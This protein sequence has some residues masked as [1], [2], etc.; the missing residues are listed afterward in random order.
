MHKIMKE[1]SLKMDR[2]IAIKKAA[3][4]AEK[5]GNRTT[6]PRTLEDWKNNQT[7]L[8][9]LMMGV[10]LIKTPDSVLMTLRPFKVRHIGTVFG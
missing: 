4:A 5:A 3:H 9:L 10:G 7:L 1:R 6:V 2:S 8:L